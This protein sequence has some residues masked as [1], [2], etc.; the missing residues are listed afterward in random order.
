MRSANFD[1]SEKHQSLSDVDVTE[2]LNHRR[3]YL[4]ARWQ[5]VSQSL[6]LQLFLVIGCTFALILTVWSFSRCPL[7]AETPVL[8]SQLS[9]RNNVQAAV[10]ATTPTSSA[11]PSSTAVLEVFQVYQPVLTPEGPTAETISSDGSL[12]TTTIEPTGNADSCTKLLMEYSFGFSYGRPFVG[13]FV[14]IFTT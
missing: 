12:N 5:L 1:A 13:K 8:Q 3:S 2:Q 4:A 6:K 11:S 7:P 14:P 10:V 9:Y